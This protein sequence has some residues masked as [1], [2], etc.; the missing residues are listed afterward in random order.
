MDGPLFTRV[1]A[2]Q[3]GFDTARVIATS[4]TS[5]TMKMVQCVCVQDVV[6]NIL[7]PRPWHV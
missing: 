1:P 2:A 4:F 3:K 6:F 7:L 5:N